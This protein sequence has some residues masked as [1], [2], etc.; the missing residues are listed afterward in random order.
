MTPPSACADP[1]DAIVFVSPDHPVR[2][3]P[4]RVIAVT[5]HAVDA[6]LQVSGPESSPSK[7]ATSVTRDRQGGPPYYWIASLQPTSVGSWRATLVRD[8]ACGGGAI[9]SKDLV[10][11][12]RAPP[13][14]TVPRTALWL[15][16]AA[17]SSAVE[18]L[19][20]AWIQ[21]LFDAPLES[22]PS[23]NALHDVLRD[24]ERNF[25]FDHLG[26]S[27]D[28]QGVT[29]RPDCADLPY[30]L[31][32]YFAYKLGLPFGW[33]RCTRGE[34]GVPPKCADFAT[35]SGPFPPIDHK[36]QAPPRWADAHRPADP[37]E[38]N[39]KRIGEFFRTTLADAVQSG[40]GRTAA[41]DK[42]SD[43]YPVSLSIGTLRPGTIFADPYGHVLVLTKRVPQT[44]TTGG[45]LLAVDGQPDGTVARKRFWRGNFLFAIDPALGSAGF[46]RF[47]TL[48]RDDA[49]GAVRRLSNAELREYSLEQY[50]G[51]V[52]G[53]YDRVEDVLSPAPLDPIQA[54]LETIQALEEQVKTR[55]GSLENGRRF[56]ASG[57]PAA[58]M[59]DGAKIFETTGSWEDFSTPS[60]DLRLLIALDVVRGLPS[61]VARR[62]ERYAMPRGKPVEEVRRDLELRL[63][64]ELRD[65]TFTY[66]RT[67]GT[68]WV[69][70]LNDVAD[71]EV[72]LEMAYNP[73]DCV[74]RRWGAPRDSKE[75]STCT[76]H[77]PEAQALKMNG[78]R[79]W[80]HERRRPPR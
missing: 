14:A 39:I 48:V 4:L 3:V 46:K 20:S 10:V 44:P 56:L 26:A 62:P 21:R 54:L 22:Q 8:A 16:R 52:E 6:E 76:A 47:R 17:W 80:F 59:P 5:D 28:E 32:A 51:G 70:S 60:R 18:N 34:G 64:Q 41:D 57:K 61:R 79:A 15:T 31:R 74:E 13:A 42:T 75:A 63:G 33:S 45:I 50:E 36:E 35:N 24:G 53:F 67:D 25:L 49:T 73:N 30:F 38:S 78:Y 27:E 72:S 11:A 77:A 66:L 65:R 68:E 71:R 1:G 55:A 12:R 9:A 58:E 69:L 2:G 40:A 43:Y 19:Y 37:R 29:V 7:V 23:W